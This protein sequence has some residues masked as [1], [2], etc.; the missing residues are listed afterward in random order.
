[1]GV[2]FESNRVSLFACIG[3]SNRANATLTR[4]ILYFPDTSDSFSSASLAQIGASD[5]WCGINDG[6]RTRE[7][8]YASLVL[9]DVALQPHG[10][11]IAS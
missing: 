2:T 7:R 5:T 4:A 10:P 9:S 3:E 8:V 1:M 6:K 11:I